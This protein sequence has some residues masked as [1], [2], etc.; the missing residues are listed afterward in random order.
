MVPGPQG[1]PGP[2]GPAG[3]TYTHI[4][5]TPASNWI[6]THNLGHYVSATIVLGDGETVVTD[7]EQ[8]SVNSAT[9]VFPNPVSGTAVFS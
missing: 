8:N 1:P 3:S 7:I 6:V 2:P 5:S 4:Q 9:L